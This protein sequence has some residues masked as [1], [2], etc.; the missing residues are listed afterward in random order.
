MSAIEKILEQRRIITDS[1]FTDD[2]FEF[3]HYF[4]QALRAHRLFQRDVDYVV[5]DG[6]VEIVDEFTD[7]FC[8]GAATRTA[9]IRRSRPRSG[10]GS[11]NGT[12][13]WPPLPSRTTSSC[14]PS[15]P[16]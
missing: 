6:K 5:Q 2:N 14:M 7:A 13:R 3:I 9:C 10:S 16:E 15:W 11:C 12:V 4:T 8:T 1:L